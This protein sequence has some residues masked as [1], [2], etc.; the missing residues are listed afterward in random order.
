LR[1]SGQIGKTGDEEGENHIT[2]ASQGAHR[3]DQY[4]MDRCSMKGSVLAS[5]ERTHVGL[6]SYIVNS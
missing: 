1:G 3:N 6:P 5:D 4:D 2:V